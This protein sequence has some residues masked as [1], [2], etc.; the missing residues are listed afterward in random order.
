MI[1]FNIDNY[2]RISLTDVILVCISTALIIFFAKHFFWD[3]LMGLIKKRQ[4]FVQ[5][6]IDASVQLKE[7]AQKTKNQYDEK[8]KS[9]GMEAHQILESARAHAGEEKDKI[10]KD[11]QVQATRLKEQASEEIERDKRKAEKEMK[12]AIS[13]VAIAAARELVQKE[14]DETVQ[15]QF[16]DE[17]IDQ[18]GDKK[19]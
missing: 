16:V 2:L 1:E 13:E 9:A 11:A 18:A 10:L 3:K 5:G 15:K 12:T 14:M 19:W 17:F 4:D 7:E 6:N 8:M